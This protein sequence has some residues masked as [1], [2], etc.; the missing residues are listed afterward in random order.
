MP[1]VS[2]IVPIYNVEKYL[3]QCLDSIVNQT[4]KDIEIIL[5]D[6]GSPDDCPEICDEYASMDNRIIVIHKENGG[7]G[8]AYNIGIKKATGEYIGFV[9]PDDY[10]EPD[11]YEV[12]YNNAKYYDTDATKC[13]FYNYNSILNKNYDRHGIVGVLCNEPTGVFNID[14]Y[15]LLCAY[16]SS[17][18]SYIY[19]SEFISSIK[20]IEA[21]GAGYCDAPFGFEVLCKAKKISIVPRAFYHW[22]VE[23]HG[24]SVSIT[25]KRVIAMADRFIEAKEIL[26]KYG[27]YEKL[28][29]IFYLHAVN[30][31]YEHYQNI[32]TEYKY[33]YFKK[34]QI[35]FNDLKTD[36]NF[37]FI[38]IRN[39]KKWI[40]NILN[41]RYRKSFCIDNQKNNILQKIFSAQNNYQDSIKHK[42]IT[43]F[44]IKMKF[45]LSKPDSER[46]K[47]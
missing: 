13:G 41:D 12:L 9:E 28:K 14:D 22:R 3:R 6:D 43:I 40:L 25:D 1:K 30:A 20:F 44:G 37:E 24:N 11:M 45:K 34:L 26:K 2:V 47:S 18:W 4:L 35:L 38:Y 39:R 27:K 36:K 33:E 46:S 7:L 5:V 31:N 17:I 10:I 16:H 8:S 19:K 21:K 32:Q 42:V 23:D 15:P 29:E